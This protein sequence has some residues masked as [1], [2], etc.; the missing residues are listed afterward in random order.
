MYEEREECEEEEQ[1]K[2]IVS[3]MP[4][5]LRLVSSGVVVISLSQPSGAGGE[6]EEKDPNT[7]P[8]LQPNLQHNYCLLSTLI[9]M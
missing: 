7:N 3:M 2:V 5:V 4:I 8:Q 9:R 1:P 6:G